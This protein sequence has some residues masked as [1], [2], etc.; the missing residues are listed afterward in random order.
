MGFWIKYQEY[1]TKIMAEEEEKFWQTVSDAK[2]EEVMLGK[3]YTLSKHRIAFETHQK[4]CQNLRQ[5]Y[6]H[7]WT[8]GSLEIPVCPKRLMPIKRTI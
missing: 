7:P 3:E 5:R 1:W 6:F 8:K 2:R 4:I